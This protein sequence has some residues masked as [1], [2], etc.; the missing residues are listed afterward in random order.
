MRDYVNSAALQEYTTKLVAKLKTLFPGT[1]TAVATVAK[2]TDHNKTYVYVGTET[3]YTAGDWY[4][5]DG[6]AWTSGGPFQATSIITDT[7]LAV[8]GEA[9]D[10]KATG[11]AISAAKAAVLNA[12]APAYSTSATYAVGDYVNYNGAIYRCTTAISTA[13]AWTAGHWAAVT[14]G[15]DLEGQVSDLK[16]QLKDSIESESKGY[17]DITSSDLENGGWTNSGEPTEYSEYIIRVNRAIPITAGDILQLD[18]G[19]LYIRYFVLDSNGNIVQVRPTTADRW[20]KGKF[21]D[22]ITN[23]GLLY[24]TFRNAASYGS[25]SEIAPSDFD[26]T[27]HI[28]NTLSSKNEKRIIVNENNISNLKTANFSNNLAGMVDGVFYKI[29][30]PIKVGESFTLSTA[31]GEGLS[32]YIDFAWYD[33]DKTEISNA[34]FYASGKTTTKTVA[35]SDMHYFK[36]LN[37]P[38]KPIMVERGSAFTK[39]SEYFEPYNEYAEGNIFVGDIYKDFVVYPD[40]FIGGSSISTSGILSNRSANYKSTQPFKLNAGDILHYR[41][42]GATTDLIVALYDLSGTFTSGIAGTGQAAMTEG[43][44]TVLSDCYAIASHRIA[45]VQREETYFYINNSLKQTAI[46]AVK[47]HDGELN[48]RISGY[49]T[50]G[51]WAEHATAFSKLFVDVTDT[52]G[53]MFFTDSHFMSKSAGEW[54]P[55][56]SAIFSYLE[57]LYYSSPCS[58]VLHGGDWL[59]TGEPRADYLPKLSAING[60]FRRNFDKYALLVGNHEC[61]NQSTEHTM[62]THDTLASTLLA[63]IG[64]TYYKY[65]ANTFVMYCF[66]SWQS[67]ALDSYANEQI[68]W[69]A[70]A[71]RE[72]NHSHIVIAI[73]IIYNEATLTGLADE[74]TKCA[75]AY[76]NRTSYTYNNIEYGFSSA[77]GKVAF[78]IAGHNHADAKGTVNN[79]PYILTTNLTGYGE[80]K[81]ANLPLPLDLIKVD[82]HNSQLTAYRASRGSEGTTRTLTILS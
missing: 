43:T 60:L 52:E 63:N 31:D 62:F 67:G 69:F 20:E 4:Y 35:N 79:I 13:E 49:G 10:A 48:T 53:F 22:T 18:T 14:L 77:T 1:P 21:V 73:H 8:A 11:D 3:G 75:D 42:C 65:E 29:F 55:F 27:V 80:T 16:T 64:K 47:T 2:M 7:T 66:D 50:L 56:A 51:G 9:A 59:G 41:L 76:N 24:I 34:R 25:A 19:T 5:W 68:A 54:E 17:I 70:N 71:L 39:Y 33:K 6:S 23:D 30:P 32:R 82:W 38:P 81:M 45:E 37:A 46:E 57:K 44:Y 58:F 12:M 15:A 28:E 61:G 26:G 36:W 40:S 72:E 78:A 74:L